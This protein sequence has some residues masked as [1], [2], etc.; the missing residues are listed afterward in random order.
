MASKFSLSA[1]DSLEP[2]KRARI[3][4]ALKQTL[5]AQLAAAAIGGPLPLAAHSR[6]QGAFFSRSKT[7]DITRNPEVENQMLGKVT[8]MDDQAFSKFAERLATIKNLGKS[9]A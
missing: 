1:L 3:E 9:R 5:E 2:E 4:A 6:S 7:T 8:E